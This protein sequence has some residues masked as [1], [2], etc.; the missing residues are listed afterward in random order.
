MSQ[1][2][3]TLEEIHAMVERM[4]D[5]LDPSEPISATVT[6]QVNPAKET[7]FVSD[8]EALAAATRE[9][10]GLKIFAIHRFRPI[11]GSAGTPA[12]LIYEEWKTR[13]QFRTQWNSQ[14]LRHFQQGVFDLITAPPDLRFYDGS[15]IFD[16]DDPTTV[17]ALATGQM[18]AWNADGDE[19]PLEGSGVDGGVRAGLPFPNPRYRDNGDG[20]ITDRRTGLIWLKDANAYGETP[21]TEALLAIKELADGQHGLSDGS[22]AGDWRLPNINE[23][24]SLVDLDSDHGPAFPD[25]H[26]FENLEATN[27]WSSSTVS[28]A[29][30]LGWY[31]AFAVAPP[32]FDLKMNAMRIWPVRGATDRVARTGQTQCYDLW[33]QPIDGAGSGQDGELQMGAPHPMPRFSDRGDGTIKDNLTG[34]IWLRDAN[35]FGSLSWGDAVQRCNELAAGK[36]GLS[37]GSDA[38]QWRLPNIHE[39]RSLVDYDYFGPALTP[40]H[41]F[42]GVRSSLYWSSTTV[43]SAPNQA[44]F[45]FLGLGPSVWDHKSVKIG[46][47][48]VRDDDVSGVPGALRDA[49]VIG[50]S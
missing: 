9:L 36:A 32:V 19:I 46:V 34:L 8:L 23:L 50:L 4:L 33:G 12:Y 27:Y 7:T 49:A 47:W 30:A 13:D 40:G 10:P 6:F 38:G 35:P 14:H 31:I 1:A 44:R 45:V 2:P 18:R 24:Q 17:E 48:P 22:G 26:P 29:P 11:Q 37:D 21:W 15:D 39:M 3:P 43:A 41:P 25:D 42:K 28:S 20:T 16:L 5:R